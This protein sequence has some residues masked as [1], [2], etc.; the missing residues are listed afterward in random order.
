MNPG[1]SLGMIV[2]IVFVLWLLFRNTSSSPDRHTE[3][4]Y[5]GAPEP[6]DDRCER[7]QPSPGSFF[8]GLGAVLLG[9]FAVMEAWGSSGN[10]ED[11]GGWDSSGEDWE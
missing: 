9:L 1:L 7:A 3:G 5:G 10:D 4:V 8:A 6:E 11:S 2:L